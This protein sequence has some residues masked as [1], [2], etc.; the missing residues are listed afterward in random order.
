MPGLDDRITNDPN[1]FALS[2]KKIHIDVDP[3]SVSKIIHADVPIVGT[4]KESLTALIEELN[5]EI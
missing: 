1:Q 4:A 5:L 3:A 2:A